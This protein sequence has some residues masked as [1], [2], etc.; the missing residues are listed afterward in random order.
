[1]YYYVVSK[2]EFVMKVLSSVLFFQKHLMIINF[3]F[4]FFSYSLQMMIFV[5]TS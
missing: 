1:M 3:Y 5:Q 2:S 4:V